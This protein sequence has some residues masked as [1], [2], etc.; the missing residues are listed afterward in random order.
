MPFFLGYMKFYS[1]FVASSSSTFILTSNFALCYTSSSTKPIAKL[2]KGVGQ[3]KPSAAKLAIVKN[4]SSKLKRRSH[5]IAS[6]LEF[7]NTQDNPIEIEE[8]EKEVSMHKEEIVFVDQ[9]KK[10]GSSRAFEGG[11]SFNDLSKSEDVHFSTG[12]GSI[13]RTPPTL[14]LSIS[15]VNTLP[16]FSILFIHLI[17]LTFVFHRFLLG[18]PY[19]LKHE[20]FLLWIFPFWTKPL[21]ML[22]YHPDLLRT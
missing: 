3:P 20:Q 12:Q 11:H 22:S 8:A 21:L 7:S 1:L 10:Q 5:R 4:T 16:L 9:S 17:F 19:I 18:L 6:K 13:G 15:Q 14:L 2:K